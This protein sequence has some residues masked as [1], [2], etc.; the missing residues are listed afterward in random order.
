MHTDW[1]T[2][3]LNDLG[4]LIGIFG[5]LF[6]LNKKYPILSKIARFLENNASTIG[7]TIETVAKDIIE[8]PAGAIVKKKLHDEIDKV[9][10]Q[11][12]NSEIAKFALVGLHSFGMVVEHLSDTQKAALIK[13]V[14]ESLPS[15]WN[16]TQQQV[17]TVLNDVQ[18]A[19]NEFKNLSIVVAANYFTEAQK[20]KLVEVNEQK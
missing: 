14:I 20:A 15:E 9:T 12:Q 13:F 7:H 8:T 16:I 11:L 17:E 3:I 5:T 10:E 18:K 19:A 2:M 4:I 6:G 1:V